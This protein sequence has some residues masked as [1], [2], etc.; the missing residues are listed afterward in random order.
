MR[1]H[2]IAD[3][4]CTLIRSTEYTPL[5]ILVSL[6]LMVS[7]FSFAFDYKINHNPKSYVLAKFQS[8][9][10][11]LLGTR[12]KRPA[13]LNFVSDLIATLHNS[14][15]SHIGLE[16]PSDQQGK[17]DHFIKT[18]DGLNDI[19]IHPQINCPEYR[20]PF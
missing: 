8:T 16:V 4:R 7:N 19:S 13:I 6:I 20:N 3:H 2:K 18:G 14:C 5:F 17:I 9:D 10:F 1:I 15:V 12:H 11:I